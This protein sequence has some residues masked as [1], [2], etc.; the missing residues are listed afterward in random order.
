MVESAI[1]VFLDD[2]GLLFR[3]HGVVTSLYSRHDTGSPD[4]SAQDNLP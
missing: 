4:R 2:D 3:R 1:G